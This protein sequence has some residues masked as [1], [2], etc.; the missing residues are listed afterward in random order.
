MFEKEDLYVKN[1]E[2]LF[3]EADE[4]TEMEKKIHK[5][6]TQLKEKGHESNLLDY[7][8]RQMAR[9]NYI[10]NGFI[11]PDI[12]VT[13]GILSQSAIKAVAQPIY[14]NSNNNKALSR[15]LNHD[16]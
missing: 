6:E 2:I 1:E 9:D 7:K 15:Y 10:S 16:V 8:L 13:C 12:G 5:L 11:N 14:L 4:L 3:Q